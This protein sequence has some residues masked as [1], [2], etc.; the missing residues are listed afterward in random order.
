MLDHI[1]AIA[2]L[3]GDELAQS[4]DATAAAHGNH[5]A[6]AA[7]HPPVRSGAIDDADTPLTPDDLSRIAME[8]AARHLEGA[9][10]DVTPLEVMTLVQ[11]ARGGR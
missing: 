1:D 5:S 3:L 6:G 9:P 2:R 11:M 7:F 10:A 4:F 8:A